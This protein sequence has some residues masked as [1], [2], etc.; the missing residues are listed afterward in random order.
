MFLYLL[1]AMLYLVSVVDVYVAVVGVVALVALI[2]IYNSAKQLVYAP[3]GGKHGGYHRHAEEPAQVVAV[4]LVAAGFGL[5]KHVEGAHHAHVHV[6]QLGR[7]VQVAFQVARVDNVDDYIGCLVY[8]LPAHIEL[9]GRIGRERVGA[10]QVYQVKGVTFELG[11]A[12]LGVDGHTA[13]VAYALVGTRGKVEK[14]RLATVG[15]A[16]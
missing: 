3:A 12:L 8:N 11:Y 7:Q 9:L 14:R 5:V 13:V 1:D 4:Y 10:R 16:H 6:Y 15:V 2:H